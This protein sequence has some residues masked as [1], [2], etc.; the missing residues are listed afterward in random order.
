MIDNCADVTLHEMDGPRGYSVSRTTPPTQVSSIERV[1]SS[2]TRSGKGTFARRRA[3]ADMRY[4]LK[5]TFFRCPTT[6]K[7]AP[8]F[9]AER[10]KEDDRFV[11]V[12]CEACGLT[13]MINRATGKPLGQED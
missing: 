1:L 5:P 10:P 8:H 9:F 2:E 3:Y 7:L 13:H 12:L 11:S 4:N 6:Q